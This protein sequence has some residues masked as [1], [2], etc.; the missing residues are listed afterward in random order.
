LLLNDFGSR[1][2]CYPVG[3]T[4]LDLFSSQVAAY[5][6]RI[7]LVYEDNTY[8]FKELDILSSQLSHCLLANYTLDLED[9]VGIKLARS[10]WLVISVLGV[11]KAGCAYVPIDP[12]YPADRIAY[13]ERD[14]NCKLTIDDSFLSGFN[15]SDFSDVAPDVALTPSNLVYMI[16]TSGSTGT[17]KGVMVEHEALVNISYG[18]RDSYGLE[19]MTVS[20]LQLASFSFDVFFGDFCRCILNGG[21]LVIS[22]DVLTMDFDDLYAVFKNHQISIVE[23]T[24]ALLVPFFQHLHSQDLRLDNLEVVVLGSDTLMVNDLRF[25]L[26]SYGDQITFINSYGLTESSID[27]SYYKFDSS[28]D[29][30]S[31]RQVSIGFPFPNTKIY[32]LDSSFNLVPPGVV[33]ELCLGGPGLARGYLNLSELTAN[34]FVNNPFE[35]GAR[36]YKTGDLAY[37]LADGSI[38]YIGRSDSQTKLNGRRI[39]LGEIEYC[40][41]LLEGVSDVSVLVKEGTSGDKFLVSYYVS[42]EEIDVSIFRRFLSD[43][44]PEYMVPITYVRLDVMPLTPNGKLDRKHLLGIDLSV[45]SSTVVSVSPRT[46][47]ESVLVNA[48]SSVLNRDSISVKDNFYNLGGD[49]IKSIQLASRLKQ[50]GYRLKV[51]QILRT[52][53]LEDLSLKMTRDL[54]EIDQSCVSGSVMLS[55]IQHYFFNNDAI[56][57]RGHY[58]QSV[59]LKS[60]LPLDTTLL[61]ECFK[62]LVTHH[63]ALRMVFDSSSE[64]VSQYNLD[65]TGVHYTLEYYD[66]REEQDELSSMELL[67]EQLQSSIDLGQGPLFK[68]GHFRLSDGDRLAL[69]VHHLVIDGVSW[70]IIL[71]DLSTLYTQYASGFS[72]SLPLKTDSYQ[73]WSSLQHSYASGDSLGSEY[74]YWDSVCAQTIDCFPT[75]LDGDDT[76]AL[77]FDQSGSFLLDEDLTELLQT[78]VHKAYNTEINDILLTGLGL[79]I[80][81]V[82]GETKSVIEL[83]GHGREDILGDIDISRTVGWF[84]SIFPFVL[85]VTESDSL[86]SSLVNVKEDLR[87]I[88]NKGL[89]YGMLKYLGSGLAKDLVTTIIFNYL[90]DIGSGSVG[91][92]EASMFSYSSESIGS[93]IAV[94]NGEHA[95]LDVSGMMISGQLRMSIGYSSLLFSKDTIARLVGCYQ[96]HLAR[97]IRSLSR[98]DTTCLTPSDMTFKGLTISELSAITSLGDIEDVYRLSPLQ[99]GIYYHWLTDSSKTMYLEQMSYR[100]RAPGLD[101]A[102]VHKAY[103]A[104]V[105]RYSILR[106]SFTNN[107]AGTLLQ[108]VHKSVAD[109]FRY[110][111]VSGVYNDSDVVSYISEVKELDRS[112]GFDLIDDHSQMRLQ[113]LDLGDDSYEFIWSHHHILMDG[114][115]MSIVIN[116]FYQ[117]LDSITTGKEFSFSPP[118]L[119]ASYIEWLDGLDQN[120]SLEYWKEYLSGYESVASI[121]FVNTNTDISSRNYTQE[122]LVLE[123][124]VFESINSLCSDLN[125]T[126]N[127]FIQ[128]VWGY[129]LSRYN[130]TNDVVYGLVVSGRPGDIS[131]VED[132]VGLFINTIP[133]RIQYEL[134]ETPKDLLTRLQSESISSNEHHYLELSKVQSQSDLGMDLINH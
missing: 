63:D 6:E 88:P 116:D 55:P 78:Q 43:R 102:S 50:E 58:N 27:S 28:F 71:E 120:S 35:E 109:N 47:E 45:F 106:T 67:G 80:R 117:L 81:D 19:D 68:I 126:Q 122:D 101:I 25:L 69:I 10:E 85:D 38:G 76:S 64:E 40:L 23:S 17:P 99:Q 62:S 18:W 113:V 70:R 8:T 9:F 30:D 128:G 41:Q 51:D 127:T 115:C 73:L 83:E 121:P 132:M 26:A 104:L 108:V 46:T 110:E 87:R 37:W 39:E 129:L 36:L 53:V 56:Q 118:I 86:G 77:T 65:T 5:P 123:G 1:E 21:K 93:D 14:S 59:L 130:N 20:Y 34:R 89:G 44:L 61:G 11:L 92:D 72:V 124:S 54:R 103:Q 13:I 98:E 114:W 42:S 105:A 3:E 66:L 32:I 90:G 48:L 133:V 119:Y 16:Y 82:F 31:C 107:Y 112:R 74:E 91:S 12:S 134:D 49:S 33:G 22:N 75:D 60:S 15:A 2:V 97:M 125:I 52:P 96:D 111:K 79:A 84:T 7:A 24:P 95:L 94:S 4:I 100:L 131:G 29:I 57:V